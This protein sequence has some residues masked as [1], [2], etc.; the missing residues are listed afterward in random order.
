MLPTGLGQELL[1]FPMV[2][3]LPGVS[4]PVI[5]SSS[6]T[7]FTAITANTGEDIA[8][9]LTS[10]QRY[11]LLDLLAQAQN[12]PR[13][14]F[15]D[16]NDVDPDDIDEFIDK[17]CKYLLDSD[18]VPTIQLY[19]DYYFFTHDMMAK[20]NG[21][22]FTSSAAA[23]QQLPSWFQNAAA[24]LDA[25]L[26][27]RF[28]Y[29]RKGTWDVQFRH[30]KGASS[31]KL[32]FFKQEGATQTNLFTAYDMYNASTIIADKI[33]SFVLTS[34]AKL[35]FGATINGKNASSSSYVC[36]GGWWIL[37]RTGD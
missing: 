5:V 28:F 30:L 26:S 19:Q 31:G 2:K 1:K 16:Y 23:A 11:L 25:W 14:T 7:D 12:S 4:F 35:K 18:A 10:P 8:V 9:V 27:S 36:F 20:T 21:N 33:Q 6:M 22:N 15:D 17:T 29:L 37:Q 3:S 34:D 24:N 32:D 13:A